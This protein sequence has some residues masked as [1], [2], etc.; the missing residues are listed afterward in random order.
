MLR[1]LDRY[2]G[3]TNGKRSQVVIQALEELFQNN[4]ELSQDFNRSG[5]ESV[6]VGMDAIRFRA[7]T[8]Q[9]NGEEKPRF[10]EHMTWPKAIDWVLPCCSDPDSSDWR[11]MV[12]EEFI[13]WIDAFLCNL[14]DMYHQ[15]TVD[16]FYAYVGIAV[17]RLRVLMRS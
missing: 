1:R 4:L 17:N 7:D 9:K 2:V 12:P 5:M 8:A 14:E 10:P 11:S 13:R 16:E 3:D 15:M 6:C